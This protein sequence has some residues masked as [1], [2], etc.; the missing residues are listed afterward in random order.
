[1]TK[2]SQARAEENRFGKSRLFLALIAGLAL[3]ATAL[4]WWWQSQN[5]ASLPGSG[6][7]DAAQLEK[8]L[9]AAGITARERAAIESLI[10][11][12]ILEHPEI[13]PE[14]VQVLQ[15]KEAAAQIGPMRGALETPFPGAV[16]GNPQGTVTLVEF[17]DFACTYCRKSVSDLEALIAS[18]PDLKVVVRELPIISPNSAPAARMALAAA[19]QGKFAAFHKAMFAQ[20]SI[21]PA[22]IEAAAQ[23]AGLDLAAAK[24]FIAKPETE[25]ELARNVEM[26]RRLGVNGTPGWL[27]GDQLIAGAVGKERLQEAIEAARKR[28]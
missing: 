23:T 22:T 25:A 3:A 19:A 20:S 12:Y 27:I 15:E 17:T 6:K 28:S 1:M 13:I 8:S 7:P 24:A 26:A 18:N 11:A 10:R 2:S 4:G 21:N 16:M 5:S 14:A 9:S